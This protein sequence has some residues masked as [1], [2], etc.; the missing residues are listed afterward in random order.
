MKYESEFIFAK[1]TA[2]ILILLI[3]HWIVSS[4][5][6]KESW[7]QKNWCFWTVVL[8]KTLES[9]LDC[10]E[11]QPSILKEISPGVHW[12]DWCWSWNSNI[13]ATWCE[14]LTH[15]KIFWCWERLKAGGEGDDREWDGWM[16]SATR[17]TWVWVNSGSW[18]WREAWCA[19]VH[20]IAKSRTRLSDW[21]DLNWLSP[22]HMLVCHLYFLWWGVCSDFWL[23]LILY[24][25]SLT[26]KSSFIF[27]Y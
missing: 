25:K 27:W 15:W 20:G 26:F 18:W 6:Y 19:V 4:L 2:I 9:P 21:T 13:L 10:K 3:S 11:I 12:K 24:F 22:F 1:W 8:K 17:W 14:E 16:A 23:L 7:V 5:D